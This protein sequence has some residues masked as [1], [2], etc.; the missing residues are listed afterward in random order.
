MGTVRYTEFET[1]IDKLLRYNVLLQIVHGAVA[2]DPLA[3]WN[4]NTKPSPLSRQAR[5]QTHA[6]THAQPTLNAVASGTFIT[7]GTLI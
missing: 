6:Q 1:A 3:C 5:A 2:L 7:P 4:Q